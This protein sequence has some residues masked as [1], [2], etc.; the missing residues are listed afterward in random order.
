MTFCVRNLCEIAPSQGHVSDR[1]PVRGGR[2]VGVVDP[3]VGV[4]GMVDSLVGA[5]GQVNEN[6]CFSK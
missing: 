2:E 4:L 5:Q 6:S 1:E 3:S